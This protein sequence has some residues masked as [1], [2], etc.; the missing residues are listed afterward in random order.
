MLFWIPNQVGND[1]KMHCQ[2][3]S[4]C[5]KIMLFES[6]FYK[7]PER[8]LGI[9]KVNVQDNLNG[10]LRGNEKTTSEILNFQLS[11]FNF[12]VIV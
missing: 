9:E 2:S 10:G 8:E 12:K 11:V 7:N 6:V 1:I 4:S 5:L 3:C